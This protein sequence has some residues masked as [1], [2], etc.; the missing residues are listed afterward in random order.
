[1]DIGTKPLGRGAILEIRNIREDPTVTM[2]MFGSGSFWTRE[3]F[4]GVCS[5]PQT[6][7]CYFE[8]FLPTLA[9][10]LG[11]RVRGWNEDH[12]LISNLPNKSVTLEEARKRGSW[13]V[14]PV[15]G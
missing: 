2:W 10:H 8:I 9:H 7:N 1:L 15:K 11:F 12:H 6:I 5:I 3:A 13:T 4:V 14:H